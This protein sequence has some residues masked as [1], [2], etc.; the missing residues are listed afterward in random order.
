M[1]EVF[2]D[3]VKGF[4]SGLN[5]LGIVDKDTQYDFGFSIEDMTTRYFTSFIGGGIGG[6]MF[7]LHNKYGPDSQN[8][9]EIDE[10][11]KHDSK[12]FQKIVYFFR[13]GKENEVRS[14]T[15][16]LW[17]QKKFGST[18]LSGYKFEVV[19]IDGKN[20]IKYAPA[21]IGETQNDLIY[22]ELTNMYD[23][24]SRIIAE[25]GLNISDKE[26]EAITSAHPQMS[27][28]DAENFIRTY[29]ASAND[30]AIFS[31]GLHSQSM[32]E[33]NSLATEILQSK[34]KLENMLSLGTLDPKT[35]KDI[36]AHIKAVK[37]GADY[38][39]EYAKLEQL[40]K[41]RDAILAGE[42]NDKYVGLLYFAG[43]AN[44]AQLMSNKYGKHAFTT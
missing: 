21:E 41:K 32:Q 29:R 11:I 33:I 9:K 5:A 20:E 24:I 27:K 37:N 22:K 30:A 40:R 36:E 15:D 17:K 3:G 16:R 13:N 38:K 44:L 4:Y 26:I 25:E 2:T 14:M 1:E 23:R 43:R 42:Y 19:T 35:D 12:H 31:L 6:A 39:T 34:V 18:N 8:S 10:A 28:D 7:G